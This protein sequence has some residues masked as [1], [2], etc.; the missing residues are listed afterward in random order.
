ML[1][2]AHSRTSL[3]LPLG[4]VDVHLSMETRGPEHC[5]ELVAALR[6]AGHTVIDETA[7]RG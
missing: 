1:D 3:A 5:A 4:D 6:A 2:V 7:E